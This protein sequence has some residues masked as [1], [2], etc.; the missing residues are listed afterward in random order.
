M[1]KPKPGQRP[2]PDDVSRVAAFVDLLTT[3]RNGDYLAAAA[4]HRE[5]ERLGI[6]IIWPRRRRDTRGAGR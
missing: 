3:R 4:A 2:H 6:K 1:Q 5:L